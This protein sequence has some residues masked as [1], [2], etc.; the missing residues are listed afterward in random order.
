[1]YILIVTVPR[2]V[3]SMA[4]LISYQCLLWF[5]LMLGE[6]LGGEG[7]SSCSNPEDQSRSF[8]PLYQNSKGKKSPYSTYVLL[9]KWLYLYVLLSFFLSSCRNYVTWIVSM[10]WWR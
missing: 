6:F 8:E 2:N 7:D 3:L 5:C 9:L 1:M 4:V 10:P